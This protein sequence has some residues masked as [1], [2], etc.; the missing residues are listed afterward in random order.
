[1]FD[2]YW[3]HIMAPAPLLSRIA[4]APRTPPNRRNVAVGLLSHAQYVPSLTATAALR[5]KAA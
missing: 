1:M 4:K 2:V 5:V 3:R